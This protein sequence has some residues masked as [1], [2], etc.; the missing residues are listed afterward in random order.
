MIIHIPRIIPS[1]SATLNYSA[2]RKLAIYC[3]FLPI[4]SESWAFSITEMISSML[5]SCAVTNSW[6]WPKLKL[7]SPTGKFFPVSS[8]RMSYQG[9]WKKG[10]WSI[11]HA[12]LTLSS[13]LI[14]SWSSL[15]LADVWAVHASLSSKDWLLSY[16]SILSLSIEPNCVI[17]KCSY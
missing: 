4:L 14:S 8:I 7:S 15:V 3:F 9:C 13:F 17:F 10:D 16:V 2:S 5:C 11:W 12:Y 6:M 1:A